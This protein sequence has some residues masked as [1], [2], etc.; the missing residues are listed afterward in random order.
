MARRG[1]MEHAGS[2]TSGPG[3]RVNALGYR[4]SIA[5][6]NIAA[7]T[8]GLFDLE[9]VV[10][11]WAA[12]P[13]HAANILLPGIREFGVGRAYSADGRLSYAAAVYAAPL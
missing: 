12:S 4:Y 10:R 8:A 1:V 7:G 5:A 11:Q 9:G 3:Q 2:G 13:G 6:E